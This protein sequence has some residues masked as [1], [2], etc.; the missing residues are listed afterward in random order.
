MRQEYMFDS[1]D[2]CCEKYFF[3]LGK[4]CVV[5][6]SCSG[7]I[8]TLKSPTSSPTQAL[9]LVSDVDHAKNIIVIMSC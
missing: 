8:T 7:E 9:Q 3:V 1:T 5:E 4:E 6:D 2:D